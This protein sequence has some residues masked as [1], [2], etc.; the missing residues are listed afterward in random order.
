MEKINWYAIRNTVLAG[1]IIFS[2]GTIL[3]EIGPSD[4][5]DMPL[6]ILFWLAITALGV[7][8][9]DNAQKIYDFLCNFLK[10]T[11]LKK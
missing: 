6:I 5:K 9:W 1:W 2:I 4:Y 8:A 11:Y 7:Y 10:Q 3:N